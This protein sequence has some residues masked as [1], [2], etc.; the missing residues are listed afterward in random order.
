MKQTFRLQLLVRAVLLLLSCLAFCYFWLTEGYQVMTLISGVFILG[1]LLELLRYTEKTTRDLTHFLSSLEF[2]DYSTT[3]SQTSKGKSFTNLY[4]EL[5]QINAHIQRIRAEKEIQYRYLQTIVEHVDIGILCLDQAGNIVLINQSLENLLKRP[6]LKHLKVL[7]K[8]HP[9]LT[10]VIEHLPEGERELLRIEVDQE[11]Q[12]VAIQATHFKL[13]EEALKLI[14]FKNIKGE[15]EARDLEAWQKLIRI[16]THEIMNSVTPIVSLTGT[17]KQMLAEDLPQEYEE[18]QEDARAGLE[19]IEFRGKG[20]LAFTEAYRSLTRIPQPAMADVNLSALLQRVATLVQGEFDQAGVILEVNPPAQA[21]VFQADADLLTQVLINLLK[22]AREAM[23]ET[24]TPKVVLSG[25]RSLRK[26]VQIEVQDNG[27]GIP[28]H[29]LERIF[30]P[31]YTT[32]SE[33]SGIGLSLSRQIL[34]LHKGS[35]SV[36]SPQGQGTTFMLV[37]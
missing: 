37:L 11:I 34:Q 16:L 23:T 29:E 27:P 3:F 7:S 6:Y 22:N 4:E 18:L 13:G 28:P 30:I 8:T 33:G 10:Q 31:F 14:S 20:L 5:N 17:L 12:E 35:L 24:P 32:K 25:R 2:E 9:Q 36:L 19:A 1:S 15:L 26:Q 21:L